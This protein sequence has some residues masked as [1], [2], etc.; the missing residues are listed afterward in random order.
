[1]SQGI[2]RCRVRFAD[3]PG[4]QDLRDKRCSF[5]DHPGRSAQRTLQDWRPQ[6]TQ[7]IT[8]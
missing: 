3:H 7:E 4:L 1:M 8:V 6:W 2:Q 5:A